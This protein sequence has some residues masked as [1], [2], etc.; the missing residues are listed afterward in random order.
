MTLSLHSK[1]ALQLL[2]KALT[3]FRT[4]SD[5]FILRCLQNWN[6]F[7]AAVFVLSL[8]NWGLLLLPH[9]IYHFQ[10]IINNQLFRAFLYQCFRHLCSFVLPYFFTFS[11]II[12][13]FYYF[14]SENLH[15]TTNCFF[16][17][18]EQNV[19]LCFALRNSDAFKLQ[20]AV[21]KLLF[22][23]FSPFSRFFW[24]SFVLF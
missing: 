17:Y 20:T 16:F 6:C 10:K 2:R 12:F 14:L 23:S 1:V 7:A 8:N 4:G 11:T 21:Q 5:D 3:F 19:N 15:K 22:L 13:C 18:F 9:F 24:H